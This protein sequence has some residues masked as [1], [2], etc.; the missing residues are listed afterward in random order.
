MIVHK[1]KYYWHIPE[2]L[3]LLQ[4]AND[5][6]IS[7]ILNKYDGDKALEMINEEMSVE[8]GID[9]F[10][11]G[12]VNSIKYAMKTRFYNV[13]KLI[14]TLDERGLSKLL[15]DR[16]VEVKKYSSEF[17]LTETLKDLKDKHIEDITKVLQTYHKDNFTFE[18]L[19]SNFSITSESGI[20]TCDLDE[21][22]KMSS[23]FNCDNKK[24]VMLPIIHYL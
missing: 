13:A 10:A 2:I 23:K 18:V 15:T 17:Y 11:Y 12:L 14:N 16:T 8:E 21:W 6:A 19:E 3:L 9:P 4:W 24:I 22:I 20:C 1:V 7:N 5:M